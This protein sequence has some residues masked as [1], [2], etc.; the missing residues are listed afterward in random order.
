M[1]RKGENIR[2][3]KDGRWEGRYKNGT[4]DDG[5]IKYSSVYGKSYSEVKNKLIEIKRSVSCTDNNPYLEKK[6]AEVLTLWLKSNQLKVKGATQTK[7]FYMVQKHIE[8]TLGKKRIST[9]TAPIINDFLIEKMNNGR[10]DGTGGLSQSYVKTMAI[11][12]ESV[13]KFAVAEGYCQPLRNHIIKPPLVKKEMQI[14]SISAQQH[15]ESLAANNVNETITGIFIALYTGLRI[16]EVCALA[17]DDIDLDNQ[18]IHVRHTISRIQSYNG[19]SY[20]TVLILDIPKTK[21]SIRDIPIS[22]LLLSILM[23]MKS[24]AVSSFVISTHQSF[25]ST[26]TFDYRYK[27][28][29]RDFGLPE[30]NFHS[31]R[32]TFATRCVEVGVDIK[33]LSQ[34]LGHSNVATTLNTYVHPCIDTMRV[35]IEKLQT[36]FIH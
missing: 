30:L 23:R 32:H 6:F 10:L 22:P 21:S 34:I 18:I 27:K 1:A 3:R 15:F 33:S 31:L 19:T 24:H 9:I 4:K 36:V 11:I 29:F 35:Q 25:T 5:T 7:Y 14:L 12:I 17:W 28:V 16:G 20:E 2:K 8:P 26:R 13:L